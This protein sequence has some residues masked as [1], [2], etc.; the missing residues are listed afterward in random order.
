MKIGIA[1]PETLAQIP[2][3]EPPAIAPPVV[4]QPAADHPELMNP[5]V[6]EEF[7]RLLK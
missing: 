5:V 7:I 2:E 4:A 6:K 1:D 3:E